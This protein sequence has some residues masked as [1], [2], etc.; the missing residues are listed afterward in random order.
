MNYPGIIDNHGGVDQSGVMKQMDTGT[1][2]PKV[3]FLYLIKQRW[4]QLRTKVYEVVF[5]F[6]FGMGHCCRAV[7]FFHHLV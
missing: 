3:F 4:P 1:I 5:K 2:S 7:L 6:Q